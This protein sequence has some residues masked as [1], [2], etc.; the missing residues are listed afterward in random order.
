MPL[1]LLILLG[2]VVLSG[3]GI[4]VAYSIKRVSID[5]VLPIVLRASSK[6]NIPPSLV[7]AIMRKE[8]GLGDYFFNANALNLEK[9]WWTKNVKTK[10]CQICL[11]S[12][13]KDDPL[14]WGSWGLMQIHFPT[15]LTYEFSKVDNNPEILFN[16][17]FNINLGARLLSELYYKYNGSI[18]DVASAY[19]SGKDYKN[20]PYITK[21]QYVP[22]VEEYKK[23]YDKMLKQ[24]GVL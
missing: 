3:T 9:G 16:P 13:W 4:A 1:W 12:K 7:L 8:S 5:E 14:K 6:Y 24:R 17:E 21:F 10:V 19:N 15:A 11:K 18:K 2:I 20:A 22:L 23:F